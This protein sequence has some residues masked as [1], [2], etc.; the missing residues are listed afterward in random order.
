M[1]A[2]RKA[3][4]EQ[5]ESRRQERCF[6]TTNSEFHTKQDYTANVIGRKVMVTQDGKLVP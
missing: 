4:A 5:A 2:E 1:A 6:D 3:A